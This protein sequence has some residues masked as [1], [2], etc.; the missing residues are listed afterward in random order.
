MGYFRFIWKF[1]FYFAAAMVICGL[2]SVATEM[3]SAVNDVKVAIGFLMY[4][5]TLALGL[6]VAYRLY[7]DANSFLERFLKESGEKE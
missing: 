1:V 5:T 6:I 4:A 2:Y 7:H 3:V